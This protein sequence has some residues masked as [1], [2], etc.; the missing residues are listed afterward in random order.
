MR[1]VEVVERLMTKQIHDHEHKH[2]MSPRLGS[3]SVMNSSANLI[4]CKYGTVQ[5]SPAN[6]TVKLKPAPATSL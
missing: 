3:I 6:A 2:N 5:S 4:H 1:E